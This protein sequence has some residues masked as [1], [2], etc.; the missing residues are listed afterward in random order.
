MAEE[1][2]EGGHD[3]SNI[4]WVLLIYTMMLSSFILLWSK[5]GTNR[6]Y[7]RIFVTGIA[8]FTFSSLAI[9][10]CGFKP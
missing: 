8:V 1:F 2:G 7:K 3:T 9:G 5:L 6:G 10:V 4:S